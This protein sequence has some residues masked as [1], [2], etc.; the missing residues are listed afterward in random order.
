MG[1]WWHHEIN[2]GID[3]MYIS[4]L[5][6]YTVEIFPLFLYCLDVFVCIDLN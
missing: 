4:F 6:L 2:D 5:V 3:I 1:F